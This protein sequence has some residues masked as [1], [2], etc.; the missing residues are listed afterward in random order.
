M[1]ESYAD[2]DHQRR[3]DVI[4]YNDGRHEIVP[5]G[6]GDLIVAA[7]RDEEQRRRVVATLTI[8]VVGGLVGAIGAGWLLNE[9]VLPLGV[10]FVIGAVGGAVRYRI[11]RPTPLPEVVA[12]D[13][14]AAIVRDYVDEFDPRTVSSVA[15]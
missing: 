13:V 7:H 4:K 6:E 3:Y 2:G 14:S 5:A 11:W 15:A 9:L 8:A 12:A 10:G 1:A